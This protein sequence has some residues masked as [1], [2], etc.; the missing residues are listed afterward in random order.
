MKRIDKWRGSAYNPGTIWREVPGMVSTNKYMRMQA[1]T[2]RITSDKAGQS[3][4][5]SDD[6]DV[7]LHVR[8]ED[9]ADG[10]REA[11]A[12]MEAAKRG[13]D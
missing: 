3:I 9:I 1:L 5:I 8:L 12:D 2:V 11:L 6:R 13:R 10:L 4:S 7:M